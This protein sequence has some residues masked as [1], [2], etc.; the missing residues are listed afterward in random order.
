M[1]DA[2][3]LGASFAVVCAILGGISLASSAAAQGACRDGYETA[4]CPLSAAVA[5]APIAPLF[6]PTGWKTVALD[7]VTIAVANPQTEAAFYSALIG[8]RL[9]SADGSRAVMDVGRW[10]SVVLQQEPGLPSAVVRGFSFV[11]SPWN[12]QAVERALKER[13]L[14]PV[15]DDDGKGFQSFHVKDPDG[16]DVQ[17]GN[18]RGLAAGRNGQGTGGSAAPTPAPFKPTGWRSVWLDHLSFRVTDY[19]RSASFYEN[20]LGWAPTYD[21]GSQAEL[22][23]G[24]VGDIIIR[25]GNPK[26]PAF[27]PS[28]QPAVLDHISIGIAP[29]DTDTV[30]AEL[31]QRGLPIR[32]D[33]STKD[34]I[35]VAAYKSYHTR[36][37]NG[38]DLQIS[39]ITQANRLALPNAVKPK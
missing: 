29:W 8:W 25:G 24:D 22:M 20:L 4:R 6:A 39:Y 27:K 3:R 12:A 9:R 16:F 26:N 35:H 21:E 34:E 38:F 23:I 11:I 18:G 37:P 36:T 14:S 28:G 31:E 15:R 17:I 30:R 32:V 13:R 2:V 7:H 10:G 19:K 1:Q 33:T 5:T